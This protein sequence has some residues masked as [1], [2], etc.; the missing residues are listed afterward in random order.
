MKASWV[1]INSRRTKKNGANV[2]IDVFY[3]KATGR[4]HSTI[5]KVGT[6]KSHMVR[7]KAHGR[8]KNITLKGTQRK[9]SR[10]SRH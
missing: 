6:K 9:R 10:R 8:W 1:K 4:K 3:D 2:V 5:R 7:S